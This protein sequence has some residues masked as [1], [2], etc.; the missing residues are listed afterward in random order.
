MALA[1]VTRGHGVASGQGADPRFPAGTLR[2]QLPLFADGGLDVSGLHPGTINLDISP[3]SYQII[4]SKLTLTKV[5]WHPD[6]PAETF[7][8][9]DC[10]LEGHPALIYYPHPETKPEHFQSE[11]VLEVLAPKLA[12]IH[13]GQTLRLTTDPHQLRIR[14]ES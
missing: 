5:R 6:C 13:Y 4:H 1:T 9:F 2:L 14:Q 8:F 7:S 3:A 12:G 11:S 10:Q